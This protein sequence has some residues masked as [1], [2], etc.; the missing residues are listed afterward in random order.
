MFPIEIPDELIFQ[1]LNLLP[2]QDQYTVS[3]TCHKANDI[4]KDHQF[5]GP[6][7]KALS[8][9]S[10]LPPTKH[11]F[12][13]VFKRALQETAFLN[14]NHLK[15]RMLLQTYPVAMAEVEAKLRTLSKLCLNPWGEE[16]LANLSMIDRLLNEINHALITVQLPAFAVALRLDCITRLPAQT[17][18]QHAH[19]F[20]D[21]QKLEL[22]DNLLE[23]LPSNIDILQNCSSLNLYNNPMRNVPPSFGNLQNLQFLYFSEGHM[24]HMPPELFRLTR[25]QWLSFSNMNVVEIDAK[26]GQLKHLTWLY[27]RDNQVSVLPESFYKLVKLKELFLEHNPLS[28]LQFH[29]VLNLLRN[30]QFDMHE[31]FRT[32]FTLLKNAKNDSKDNE[33][34]DVDDLIERFNLL[35][36]TEAV[37]PLR[38]HSRKKT[39]LASG[40][41]IYTSV[42]RLA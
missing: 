40:T 12:A 13:E 7:I 9:Q 26:I 25:L 30:I 31:A 36:T 28:P 41:E 2:L 33:E 10:Q 24:P 11:H 38:H 14:R 27:L 23:Q 1:I 17:L 6:R 19:F 3:K 32:Q 42:A 34:A 22:Q 39:L 29:R 21:L 18:E 37:T 15:I 20:K 5:W 35:S 4:M 8:P 16:Y